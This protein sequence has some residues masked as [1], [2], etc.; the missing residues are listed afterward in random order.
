[1]VSSGQPVDVKNQ[2]HFKLQNNSA[3]SQTKSAIETGFVQRKDAV[4]EPITNATDLDQ[5][6]LI[7]RLDLLPFSSEN[8]VNLLKP[9]PASK[10][11]LSTN[12]RYKENNDMSKGGSCGNNINGVSFHNPNNINDSI[13]S[14]KT[15]LTDRKNTAKNNHHKPGNYPLMYKNN[16]LADCN[17][18]RS[19][20]SPSSEVNSEMTAFVNLTPAE[21]EAALGW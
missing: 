6:P 8:N 17:S 13:S 14:Q 21:I 15:C 19:N 9:D 10:Q 16:I 2:N 20:V 4:P 11:N 7:A 12:D 1:M 18:S 5:L 3:V